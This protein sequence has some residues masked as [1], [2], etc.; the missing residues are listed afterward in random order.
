MARQDQRAGRAPAS[1]VLLPATRRLAVTAP[2]SAAGF[3]ARSQEAQS[4]ETAAWDSGDRSDSR[5]RADGRDA[6]ASSVP[7]QAAAV[8]LLRAGV[9][10]ARQRRMARCQRAEWPW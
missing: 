5:R 2:G 3:V 4:L 6:D 1:G 10:K 7:H 8:E 9:R